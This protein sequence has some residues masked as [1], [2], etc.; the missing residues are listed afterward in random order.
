LLAGEVWEVLDEPF[1]FVAG[2][3]AR[4]DLYARIRIVQGKEIRARDNFLGYLAKQ[5]PLWVKL[6]AI[7]SDEG[8]GLYDAERVGDS[9]LR[10][11]IARAGR[12]QLLPTDQGTEASGK[13]HASPKQ[14]GVTSGDCTR[15]C[16][17]LMVTLL[18]ESEQYGLRSD[19][20]IEV[21]SPGVNREL[22]LAEHFSGAV[23][24][25]IKV[26]AH[27]R[28]AEAGANGRGARSSRSVTGCLQD[29]A[30]GMLTVVE[31]QSEQ[32]V[33]IPFAEIK[34]ARVDF[35]F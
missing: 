8:V 22:R 10:V 5:D 30:E 17:R 13:E 14:G 18:A 23:G 28:A 25:R 26:V 19:A 2:I 35:K 27:S 3:S 24:E 34:K 33:L 29:F 31:E 6:S 7:V 32:T 12:E 21:S 16:R 1:R 9:L 20:Q 15:L 11:I 4:A